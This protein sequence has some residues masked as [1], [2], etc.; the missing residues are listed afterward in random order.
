MAFICENGALAVDHEKVLYQD[1]F[2]PD[3]ARE[4]VEAIDAKEGAEFSCATREFY[5]IRPN[6]ALP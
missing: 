1:N 2:E 5:Y 3:L 4:I 6:T